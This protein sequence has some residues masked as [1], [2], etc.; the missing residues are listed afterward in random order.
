MNASRDGCALAFAFHEALPAPV[1]AHHENVVHVLVPGLVHRKTEYACALHGDEVVPV[2]AS[3]VGAAAAHI[4]VAVAGTVLV[5][6][7]L[8]GWKKNK[9]QL[10][11]DATVR[12]DMLPLNMQCSE[13][14]LVN[15]ASVSEPH[16][17][18][19]K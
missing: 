4:P 1:C 3:H 11:N 10:D 15:W 8:A 5:V 18:V 2:R 6:L 14:Y 17:S 19:F 9:H 16:T 12:C 13:R 7:A